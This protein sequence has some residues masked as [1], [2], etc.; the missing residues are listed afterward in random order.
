MYAMRDVGHYDTL[1]F[2]DV[3]I[4]A[5]I[6]DMGGWVE[7]CVATEKELSFHAREFEKH[8]KSYCLHNPSR[9]PK[10]LTGIVNTTNVAKGFGAKPPVLIGD[11]QQALQVYLNGQDNAKL[12]QYKFLSLELLKQ[13]EH[14]Q[15]PTL[16]KQESDHE[17]KND[18]TDVG[19]L[20]FIDPNSTE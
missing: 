16:N 12:L 8:Y 18:L 10:Q 7:L 4:H 9:Y 19:K 17:A 11:E 13:L 6:H 5:V 1:V 15:V 3:L 20:E 14:R 2:D